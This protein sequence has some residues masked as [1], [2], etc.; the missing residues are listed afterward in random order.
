M[1]AE[2][3]G[4][5]ALATF[6]IIDDQDGVVATMQ[7]FKGESVYRCSTSSAEAQHADPIDHIVAS[8]AV[9]TNPA[10]Y[11]HQLVAA[12]HSKG[13]KVR[14]LSQRITSTLKYDLRTG[15]VVGAA[16]PI[17]ET[18]DTDALGKQLLEHVVGAIKEVTGAQFA[19][20]QEQIAAD[21]ARALGNADVNSYT[22]EQKAQ[23]LEVYRQAN[24]N[25]FE[26]NDRF[27]ALRRRLVLATDLRDYALASSDAQELMRDF[28]GEL[29]QEDSIA[30]QTTP[31]IYAALEGRAESAIVAFESLLAL[32]DITAD[33]RGWLWRN[34]SLALKPEDPTAALAARHSIDA[35]LEEG[36]KADAGSSLMRQ[37]ICLAVSDPK[38]AE[39]PLTELV[40]LFPSSEV[41]ARDYR[42]AALHERAKW[43]YSYGDK[44]GAL[45]DAKSAIA[46]RRT[47]IGRENLLASSL[48][49]AAFAAK[50]IGNDEAP[51]FESEAQVLAVTINAKLHELR[52]GAI[53]LLRGYNANDAARIENEA[54]AIGHYDLAVTAI[55]ARAINDSTLSLDERIALLEA[56]A[57]WP[58]DRLD[59][60][61]RHV[62]QNIIADQLRNSGRLDR[63]IPIY[64]ALSDAT[65]VDWNRF[66]NY[67][68][69]LWSGER[70][71]E[72]A[73]AVA[74]RIR[75]FGETPQLQYA[76]GRSLCK[77]GDFSSAIGPLRAAQKAA[78]VGSAF[79]N[80]VSG[81]LDEALDSGAT[82]RAVGA[83][84]GSAP[85]TLPDVVQL[86]EDFSRTISL[87]RG[88]Y[89]KGDT[90]IARPEE[91]AEIALHMFMEARFGDRVMTFRQLRTNGG[92]V[93]IFAQFQG[94]AVVFE[95]KMCGGN[96]SSTYASEGEE[97]L[98]HY[99]PGRSN[100]GF[101]VVLDGR[102][103]D[104]G[105]S[106]LTSE[107]DGALS[108]REFLIDVRPRQSK[109]KA[110]AKGKNQSAKTK[111]KQTARTRKKSKKEA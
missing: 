89:W 106:L 65:P 9:G 14:V 101:L 15:S 110:K 108:I 88:D 22:H 21:E 78:Q 1:A 87:S 60:A 17:F 83:T 42:A 97:Q 39:E 24:F 34:L 58:N 8:L 49:L 81:L 94:L 51:A 11:L 3:P 43:R 48:F 4:G 84:E 56:C 45:A 79:H 100:I 36:Q 104:Y 76:Y 23:L 31:A 82:P 59:M 98:R 61:M 64:K 95:L 50:D 12:L 25:N 28:S 33:Q 57:S 52:N 6:E 99:M 90:W 105:N 111:G 26:R 77:A 37:H 109:S 70:W 18:A 63:A 47:L 38:K 91:R 93:D 16:T 68:N 46:L 74:S 54:R 7:L 71:G 41:S 102:L 40:E 96:Y 103:D 62:I 85:V 107:N 80:F 13:Y 44:A 2:D 30:L 73:T 19:Q 86:I 35:F 66:G 27:G 32:P 72:A 29:G 75:M 10:D 20:L 69:A 55:I 5:D 67:I 92:I 53:E